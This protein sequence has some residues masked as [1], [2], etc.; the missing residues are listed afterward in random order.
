MIRKP[1]LVF[2]RVIHP[3]GRIGYVVG[4][5]APNPAVTVQWEK[6]GNLT[7]EDATKLTV[8]P[9]KDGD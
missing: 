5:P 2:G 6:R 4:F 1:S 3:D 9:A 7:R 8:S